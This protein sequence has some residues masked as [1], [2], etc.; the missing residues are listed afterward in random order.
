MGSRVACSTFAVGKV[1]QADYTGYGLH[2]GF[3][4]VRCLLTFLL[5]ALLVLIR[6]G[7]DLQ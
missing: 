5:L 3:R 1:I 7:A 6:G 2:T 4:G